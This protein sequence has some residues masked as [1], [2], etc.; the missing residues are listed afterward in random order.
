MPSL[1]VDAG[2]RTHA[3]DVENIV[4]DAFAR[5]L[6]GEALSGLENKDGSGLFGEAVR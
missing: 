6:E 2:V 5:G 3:G 4:A 1:E